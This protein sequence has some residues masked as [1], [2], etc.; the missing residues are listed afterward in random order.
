M[1]QRLKMPLPADMAASGGTCPQNKPSQIPEVPC[2]EVGCIS[3]R[4]PWRCASLKFGVPDC[5][6]KPT[7]KYDVPL[8][9]D[10]AASRGT[11]SQNKPFQSLEVSCFEV[12][13]ISLKR[14]WRYTS[15]KFGVPDCIAAPTTYDVPIPTD[16]TASGG[17]CSQNKPSQIPEVPCFEVGHISLIRPWRY[18]SSKFGVPDCVAAT[19]PSDVVPLP[20]DVAA[21]GG[22]CSQN[23]QFQIP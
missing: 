21:S 22:T 7:A 9:A 17:T 2:F 10:M 4:R 1:H 14:P 5:I 6:A 19:T 23:K 13:Q 20:A 12:G 16:M 15:S 11:G 3:L 18:A 8:P